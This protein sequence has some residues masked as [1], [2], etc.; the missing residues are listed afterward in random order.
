MLLVFSA[1]TEASQEETKKEMQDA[2][3]K[4]GHEKYFKY[5][6]KQDW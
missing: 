5:L 6:E 3:D 2:M 4:M 1:L